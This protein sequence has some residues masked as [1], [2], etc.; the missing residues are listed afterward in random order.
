MD[1]SKL[2][3]IIAIG[4]SAGSLSPLLTFF[5]NTLIDKVSYVILRHIPADAR[6]LLREILQKHSKLE[7]IEAAN[8][9]PV[10]SNKVY[11]LP[12]GHYMTIE[13][14]ILYLEARIGKRNCAIDIFME[15]LAADF[16]ERSI[17]IIL[18][19]GGSNGVKG[20]MSVK[21]AGGAVLVQDP[22]SSEAHTMP[23]NVINSGAADHILLPGQMPEVI[24][25]YVASHLSKLV[26]QPS[27]KRKSA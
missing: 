21:K 14:G 25:Q 16:K 11:L 2:V 27:L 12:P 8:N 19:G 15:S 23:L 13:R 5:D 22:S 6:S 26:K 1:K 4:G 17:V 7:V 20:A 24:M 9:M 10:E 3:Y 18:S